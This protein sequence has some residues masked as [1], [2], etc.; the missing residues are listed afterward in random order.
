MFLRILHVPLKRKAVTSAKLEP[1]THIITHAA[2]CLLP[3]AVHVWSKAIGY[4]NCSQKNKCPLETGLFLIT[5]TPWRDEDACH[6]SEHVSEFTCGKEIIHAI[7]YCLLEGAWPCNSRCQK[8]NFTTW[9]Q[10]C[11]SRHDTPPLF[12]V[13]PLERRHKFGPNGGTSRGRLSSKT[14]RSVVWNKMRLLLVS[15][16]SLI[17]LER[18]DLISSL[19]PSQQLA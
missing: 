15:M 17:M 2:V 18:S 12:E 1:C 4:L 13:A 19:D 9:D 14:V 6:S 5:L 10:S 16:D 11:I 3:V 8:R 7:I